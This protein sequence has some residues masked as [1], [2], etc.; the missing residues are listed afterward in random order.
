VGGGKN[1]WVISYVVG[2]VKNVSKVNKHNVR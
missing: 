1:E 2:Y